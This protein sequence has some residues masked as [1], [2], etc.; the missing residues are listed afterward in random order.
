[1]DGEVG[2]TAQERRLEFAGEEAFATAL[3]EGPIGLPVAGGDQLQQLRFAT[4]PG[5]QVRSDS[6]GLD[7]GE[8]A[9]ASGE[10][11]FEHGKEKGADSVCARKVLATVRC[12]ALS[13]WPERP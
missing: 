2:L 3:F 11:R 10:D 6:R 7:Q 8:R 4:Q 5:P 13:S 1:M 9:L 12:A